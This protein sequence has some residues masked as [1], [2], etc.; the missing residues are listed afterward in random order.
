MTTAL[1][2]GI[3]ISVDSR[4]E[5]KF[6][7]P[8]AKLFM[9]SYGIR[10]ENKNEDAIQLLSRYWKI[11][12]S[13]THEREVKGEGVIGEKPI[14]KSGESYTYR[15]SCDFTTDMGKM[16]GYYVMRNLQTGLKFNVDIP[17]FSLIVP[18]KLN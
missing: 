8:I 14:I 13:N 15:S 17:E 5:E 3:I 10:I 16:S 4:Y 11:T 6:S 12:D 2:S 1:N 7:N 18:Y 9:F